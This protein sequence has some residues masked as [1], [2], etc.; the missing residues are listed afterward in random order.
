M[1]ELTLENLDVHWKRWITL[2]KKKEIA[3]QVT[4]RRKIQE[5]VKNIRLLT[6]N[7]LF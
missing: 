6:S 3:K 4:F 7:E 5:K 1:L 2:I